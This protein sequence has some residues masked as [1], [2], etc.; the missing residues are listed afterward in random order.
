MQKLD[1]RDQDESMQ[2]LFIGIMS[3]KG[4]KIDSISQ[5]VAHNFQFLPFA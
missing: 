2:W 4:F 1:L 5:I 3:I